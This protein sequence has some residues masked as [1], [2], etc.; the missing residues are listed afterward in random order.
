[1]KKISTWIWSQIS[2][3]ILSLPT[4]S[5]GGLQMA[6]QDVVSA[7]KAEFLAAEDAALEQALGDCFD[8]GEADG[9]GP[10][11]TQA[12]VDAAK[13]AGKAE[14]LGV[15]QPIIDGLNAKIAQDASDLASAVQ[16]G[17]DALAALQ[18]KLDEAGVALADMT[19]KELQ[20]EGVVQGLKDAVAAFQSVL[21]GLPQPAPVE[22]S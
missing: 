6:K 16:A 4:L 7:K 20:E 18:V 8:A 3:Y 17:N 10:G 5:L 2:E 11:F 12:D 22:P 15:D 1:M 14:Q 13:E 21:A 9:N 19:A